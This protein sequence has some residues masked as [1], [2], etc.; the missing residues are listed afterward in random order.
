V[1]VVAF[2]AV[3]ALVA[4][5]VAG[6]RAGRFLYPCSPFPAKIADEP[7]SRNPPA[8]IYPRSRRQPEP[9]AN[10]LAGLPPELATFGSY[11]DITRF[12][13]RVL[14]LLSENRITAWRAAVL[15][16]MAT[17]C[18]MCCAPRNASRN[19]ESAHQHEEELQID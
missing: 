16:Y 2:V 8:R 9:Q 4:V 5:V 3:V 12:L 13:A 14:T 18:S 11:A 1:V 6:L 10:L 7:C 15:S 19:Y 17:H